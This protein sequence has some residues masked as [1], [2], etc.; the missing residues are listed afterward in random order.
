MV[1][2]GFLAF[3]GIAHGEISLGLSEF[4]TGVDVADYDGSQVLRWRNAYI[5][6]L[7]KQDWTPSDVLVVV[8][9]NP[10]KKVL[11][12]QLEI[13]DEVSQDYW[14]RSNQS[15]ALGPGRR[16]FRFSSR[17]RAGEALRPGRNLDFKKIRSLIFARD[18]S[19]EGELI[20]VESVKLISEASAK[21]EGVY[22]FNFGSEATPSFPGMTVVHGSTLFDSK[23]GYGFV[24]PKIWNP[25]RESCALRGPDSLYQN[26]LMIFGGVFKVRLPNGR[27]HVFMNIDHP[28]GFWGEFPIFKHR[29]VRAQHQL[30][31]DEKMDPSSALKSFFQFQEQSDFEGMDTFETYVA[32]IF[33]EKTFEVTVKNGILDL[34]FENQGCGQIPCFGM[35]LSTVV[36]YPVRKKSTGLSYLKF[37]LDR[38]KKDFQEQF[39]QVTSPAPTSSPKGSSSSS[40]AEWFVPPLEHPIL[41]KNEYS[42]EVRANSRVLSGFANRSEEALLSFAVRVP[43]ETP[44]LELDPPILRNEKGDMLPV[45]AWHPG[46]AI[47]KVTRTIPDGSQFQVSERYWKESR[48]V[49]PRAG[50]WDRALLRIKVP[51]TQ[52]PGMYKG[53]VTLR[54]GT[55]KWAEVPVELRIFSAPLKPLDFGLGPFGST[56]VENWWFDLEAKPRARS[57]LEQSLNRMR[58]DGLTS[59]SFSPRIS[60]SESKA[61]IALDSSR[62]SAMMDLAKKKGFLELV[63]YGDVFP[64]LNLCDTDYPSEKMETVFRTLN[65]RSRQESWL[66]LTLILC[67]EPEGDTLNAVLARMR[68]WPKSRVDDPVRW[69]IT[70]H[71]GPGST[72][73]H[74]AL[75]EG[76]G[77]PFVADFDANPHFKGPWAF[78][79]NS[80]RFGFGFR[81]FTLRKETPLRL[82]L[83]WTWNQNAGNPYYAL[84]GREDDYGWCNSTESGDLICS[85]QYYR[86]VL[87]GVQDYRYA[88]TLQD[89]LSASS[90]LRESPLGQEAIRLLAEVSKLDPKIED[91]DPRLNEARLK[92]AELI[93]RV[94]VAAPAQ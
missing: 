29:V 51:S 26:C 92:I 74:Q 7:K 81:L 12:L 66:P 6:I 4:N 36:I 34:E 27:Y 42:S 76:Q 70:T 89:L 18:P 63:G 78:Y 58:E 22:A 32:K 13:R 30:V 72:S 75:V 39:Y 24:S 88:R 55:R 65:Q 90:T 85:L 37:V 2:A 44:S 41:Q 5:G 80:S 61:Q 21:P 28:G 60:F 93:E 40:A 57:L 20:E 45:S 67:D 46:W 10:G 54:S 8:L 15:F 17:P 9:K 52:S 49:Q 38:R 82:R 25:Y 35:A 11:S 47:W 86:Q 53:K 14:S 48:A 1:F 71:L 91:W 59:F 23:V 73:K 77:F 19:A 69:S 16:E 84:D 62:V 68:K 83:A 3:A 94:T 87:R 43:T 33:R 31:V 64:G 50:F 56:I 79:N